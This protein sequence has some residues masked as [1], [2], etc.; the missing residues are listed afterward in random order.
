MSA[1]AGAATA[2]GHTD[3]SDAYVAVRGL[4]AALV[5]ADPAVDL[6]RRLRVAHRPEGEAVGAAA[7]L[8]GSLARLAIAAEA[9]TQVADEAADGAAGSV[10]GGGGAAVDG[11]SPPPPTAAAAAGV[12][13]GAANGG[14]SPPPPSP[15][16]PPPPPVARP[17]RLSEM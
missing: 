6:P 14:G 4:V 12:P 1:A 3:R 10:D 8:L 15:P 7:A 16:P 11:A 9:A 2:A 13:N 5:G 17:E